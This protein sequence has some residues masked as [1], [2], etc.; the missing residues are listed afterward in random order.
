MLLHTNPLFSIYFGDASDHLFPQQ[1]RSV[2][3]NTLLLQEKPFEQV[4]K[5]MGIDSLIFLHQVHGVSGEIITVANQS[6]FRPFSQDGDFIITNTK[7]GIGVLTADCLPLVFHDYFHNVVMV[8]HAGWRGS[9]NGVVQNALDTMR[10]K[11]STNREHLRVFFGPSAKACCYEVSSN[12]GKQLEAY[13]FADQ[14]ILPRNGKTY[15]DLPGFNRLVL[16][17][18]GIKK[19]VMFLEYNICTMCNDSFYSYR[20]QGEQAGRQMT[21]VC[22]K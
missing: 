2:A 8:V 20:R 5:T 7:S 16:E 15:F 22:L 13:P 11:F 10:S 1:Y 6:Q 17:S 21:V 18:F 9:V 19:E 12:F 14:V 3:D 4:K